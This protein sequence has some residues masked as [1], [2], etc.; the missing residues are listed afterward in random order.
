MPAPH[1]FR[2]PPLLLLIDMQ[3]AVD[4][5]SWGPRNHPQAEQVCARLLAAW[6]ERGLP[7]IHIRHDSVEPAS[8][9]RP[10]RPGHAFKSETMPL[11]GET[12]IAKQT[13]SAFIGTG[14][15][16]LLREKGWLEL[17]VVGV[18][19]SN[20]VEATV[21]MAGNLGFDVCLAEDACFTFDKQDWQGRW[22]SA[23]EVHAM[24]LANLDGE[25]CRVCGSGD[26]L[27]ALSA[28]PR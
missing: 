10:D 6:R 9:F 5:P 20:S 1:S 8:T 14:L 23:E 19:T 25:Y 13:N 18:S 27:A 7:L 15:E 22:R 24:S 3:Q 11:P 28:V 12:V 2:A 4:D 21:R 26:V 16:A 17:V